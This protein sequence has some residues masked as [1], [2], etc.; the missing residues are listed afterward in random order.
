MGQRRSADSEDSEPQLGGKTPGS[1]SEER[2][3][4]ASLKAVTELET[5]KVC[6][7]SKGTVSWPHP[8]REPCGGLLCTDRRV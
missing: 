3:P 8:S 7:P 4:R 5:T 6:P 2:F 1:W